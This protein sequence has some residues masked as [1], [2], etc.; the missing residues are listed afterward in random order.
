MPSAGQL[1][2]TGAWINAAVVRSLHTV[3][4]TFCHLSSSGSSRVDIPDR[5][6]ILP[7]TLCREYH[8]AYCLPNPTLSQ[9]PPY[10]FTSSKDWHSYRR[11]HRVVS[12]LGKFFL[13]IGCLEC[14]NIA[15]CIVT[16]WIYRVC[17]SN[18]TR[19][20]SHVTRLTL[21][22]YIDLQDE[23]TSSSSRFSPTT[24]HG[25]TAECRF[26]L[27]TAVRRSVAV[28]MEAYF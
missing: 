18:P 19:S 3:I 14:I 6:S 24:R 23:S 10:T 12:V 1:A 2:A 9:H 27:K 4:S 5:N 16:S 11:L 20:T 21:L 7:R 13:R 25:A 26:W 15:I 22:T 28:A 17:D 8:V